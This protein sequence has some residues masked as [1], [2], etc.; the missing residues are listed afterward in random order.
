LILAALF[1]NELYIL[2]QIPQALILIHSDALT[3]GMNPVVTLDTVHHLRIKVII[4]VAFVTQRAEVILF[5]LTPAVLAMCKFKHP[6]RFRII[7]S[8][9]PSTIL[10]LN[11]STTHPHIIFA[12]WFTGIIW[13][14]TFHMIPTLA[15]ITHQKLVLI[16]TNRTTT[17]IVTAPCTFI[18]WFLIKAKPMERLST[19]SAVKHLFLTPA[20]AEE[21]EL[22][23]YT[24]HTSCKANCKSF[25]PDFFLCT[26]VTPR[27]FD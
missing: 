15:T 7:S 21:T 8:S 5:P 26:V 10:T 27:Y 19:H 1:T 16:S 20:A 17:A 18:H 6:Q 9:S 23:Y 24:W 14:Q 22:L 11:T 13:T 4:R 3:L 12:L 25:L 2:W